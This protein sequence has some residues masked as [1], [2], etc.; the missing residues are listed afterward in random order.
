MGLGLGVGVGVGLGLG[1]RGVQADRERDACE[2]G[3]PRRGH[4]QR[5]LAPGEARGE[6][7]G[8]AGGHRLGLERHELEVVLE[9]RVEAG[10]A[11]P[12]AEAAPLGVLGQR[13]GRAP[14]V[15]ERR[16]GALPGQG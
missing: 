16:L 13:L 7:H 9:R 3:R 1:V 14:L 8:H 5:A 2:V 4:A 6:R 11:L 10:G 15:L 12:A